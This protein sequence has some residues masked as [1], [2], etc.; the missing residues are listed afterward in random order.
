MGLVDLRNDQICLSGFDFSESKSPRAGLSITKNL[1][2][3]VKILSNPFS[4]KLDAGYT[5]MPGN[6]GSR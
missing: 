1:K 3:Y 5:A 6:S 2:E 4:N